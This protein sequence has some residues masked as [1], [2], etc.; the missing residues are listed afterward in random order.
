MIAK[1]KSTATE[2]K[3]TFFAWADSAPTSDFPPLHWLHKLA[4]IILISLREMKENVLT[5]RAGYLTYALLLSMVPI[6]AMS[7]AVVKGLGGGD[8]LRILAYSYIDTLEETAPAFQVAPSTGDAETVQE[9]GNDKQTADFGAHLR[10]AADKIFN[11]V[12]QTNFAT[13][14]TFGMVGIFLSVILVLGQIEKSLNVIWKVKDGRSIL[15]KVAD[16]I[17]LMILFPISINVALAAG[18]MLESQALNVHLDQF[19]PIVW[20]QTLLLRGVPIL[21]LSLTLYV[22]YVFFPNTKTGGLSTMIGAFVAGFFWFLTQNIYLSMQ[23]GVAK[24]NAIY[25][26]FATIPL[27]LAW[28]W[29][30]WLFVLIGAQLAY[31]IQNEPTYHFTI[32]TFEPA[33]RLSATLDVCRS[34][35]ERFNSAKQTRGEDLIDSNRDYPPELVGQTIDTLVGAGLLHHSSETGEII[36]SR[37]PDKIS[38]RFIV[39]T[40]LGTETPATL[41]GDQAAR[42]VEGAADRFP[43]NDSGASPSS[44]TPPENSDEPAST[45]Q[46]E[47]YT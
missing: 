12:D 46:H 29:V 30:A 27:F 1:A 28:V 16:Y 10:S 24:Y 19:L 36:L 13:L 5:L 2:K 34:V 6:L 23:I 33:L 22:I 11:Y 3:D 18:T 41:G 35:G 15:R 8:Q 20:L 25:G 47:N 21:F 9:E 43:D 14:G 40:V 44:P 7:T 4:R 17:A 32:R 39:E 26:S 37:P 38:S 42:A 45:D 31:A